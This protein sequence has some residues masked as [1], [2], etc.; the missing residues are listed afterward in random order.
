MEVK[1]DDGLH[2]KVSIDRCIKDPQSFDENRHAREDPDNQPLIPSNNPPTDQNEIV[3]R[4][5]PTPTPLVHTAAVPTAILSHSYLRNGE[6]RLTVRFD[7][8]STGILPTQALPQR[9]LE[10]YF[11]TPSRQSPNRSQTFR[12]RGRGAARPMVQPRTS[13]HHTPASLRRYASNIR[14]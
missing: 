13:S 6:I 8:G 14:R 5:D 7:D 2:L 12:R 3:L 9:I 4:H 11:S 1:T 10:P